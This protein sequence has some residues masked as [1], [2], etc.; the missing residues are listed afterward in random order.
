MRTGA[1]GF[2]RKWAAIDPMDAA[3]TAI[4]TAMRP[5]NAQ[6]NENAA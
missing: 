5:L 4:A 2:N 6:M 3:I 1:P